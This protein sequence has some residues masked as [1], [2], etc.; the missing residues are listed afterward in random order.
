MKA[1]TISRCALVALASLALAALGLF[2]LSYLDVRSSTG[3]NWPTPVSVTP[4]STHI[5]VV[6]WRVGPYDPN[7]DIAGNYVLWTLRPFRKVH[8]FK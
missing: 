6:R 8:W 7:N 4:N 1:K 3:Q 5:L 2:G